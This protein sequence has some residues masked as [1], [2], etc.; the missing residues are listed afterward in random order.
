M[1]KYRKICYSLLLS[2]VVGAGIITASIFKVQANSI[3]LVPNLTNVAY[4]SN[5]IFTSSGYKGQCTWFTYGRVLEKLD[6]KLSPAFY[7]NAITWWDRNIVDKVY[8][9]GAQPKADSIIVWSGGSSGNGHV[10]YAEKVEGDLVYF[11][12]GNFSAGGNYDGNLE[13]LSKESIKNR[14]NCFLKGY[15]YLTEKYSAPS[16]GQV[17]LAYPTSTL[18]VRSGSGASFN[19]IGYLHCKDNVTIIE[20]SGSWCKIQYSNS[21]G[22][23]AASFV[24]I[25]QKSV[26]K[27]VPAVKMGTVKLANSTSKLNVRVSQSG[28]IINALNNGNIVT[29]LGQSG[30]FFKITCGNINGYVSIKYIVIS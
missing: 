8:N 25:V 21:I 20:K 7:G 11:N 18:N 17:N 29:I 4:S 13:V 22:Y 30:D 24:S 15:I 16:Y 6:I 27:P 10:G 5:N 3:I 26:P 28:A 14:G 12:E 9:Y 19:I 1:K 23:V 2:I